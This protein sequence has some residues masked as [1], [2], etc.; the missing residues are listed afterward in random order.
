MH[1]ENS[2]PVLLCVLFLFK[3]HARFLEGLWMLHSLVK[4][5]R[6][7]GCRWVIVAHT[8]QIELCYW[9][10][11]RM[12]NIGEEAGHL[13]QDCVCT[14]SGWHAWFKWWWWGWWWDHLTCL[15]MVL[16]ISNACRVRA[17]QW[18]CAPSRPRLQGQIVLSERFCTLQSHYICWWRF[19]WLSFVI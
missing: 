10:L 9:P 8:G 11:L 18:P 2:L 17:E 19:L 14:C 15:P 5:R 3:I 4:K 7:W 12:N 6:G 16:K 1:S 13:L